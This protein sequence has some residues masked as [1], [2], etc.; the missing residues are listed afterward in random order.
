[1]QK[2]PP[3]VEKPRKSRQE[4][5]YYRQLP[6]I[7]WF[8]IVL[9]IALCTLLT[10]GAWY[11]SSEQMQQKNM[12]RF[13]HEAEQVVKQVAERI[14]LYEYAAGGNV[15]QGE[16]WLDYSNTSKSLKLDKTSAPAIISQLMVGSLA[17]PNRLVTLKI[18][19]ETTLLYDDRQKGKNNSVD[20]QPLFQQVS[21]VNLYGRVWHFDIETNLAFRHIVASN[22]SIFILVFGLFVDL[23]LLAMFVF[24]SKAKHKAQ[25][26]VDTMTAE[27]LST[28]HHLDK[29]TDNLVQFNE[30]QDDFVYIVS[31]DLKAPLRGI[32]QLAQ[33]IEED[34]SES[35]GE[36]TTEH[37]K[38]MHNRISRL[39]YLLDDLLT[40]SRIRGDQA[41]FSQV[42]VS[43][44]VKKLFLSLAP[45]DGFTLNCP[46]KLPVITALFG[47]L[48]QVFHHLIHNSIKHHDK[49]HGT[50]SVTA[51]I[52][53]EGFEF[54]V[55][56]DGPGINPEHHE[57]IFDVFST[58]RPRD[59]VEG[60]GMGLAI[61]KKLLNKY[62]GK[63]TIESGEGHGTKMTFTWPTEENLR[64]I[65]GG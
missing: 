16:Q 27:L 4:W 47:P 38:L 7:H 20:A 10:L 28:T 51:T 30:E 64:R 57:K 65:N 22:Q 45:S 21:Q 18:S 39:E 13:Q 48:E 6:V 55:S 63:I 35:V 5:A 15:N 31:H 53:D 33:W 61:V 36:Q 25:S 29:S 26:T 19:D 43:E 12:A 60:S 32:S 2:V 23:L 50:V 24:V 3:E 62:H 58:L 34:I 49:K 54:M 8:V 14:T 9:S 1:M 41:D 44:L 11:F 17:T 37:L 46:L 59:E 40:Y 56:D 42:D 52:G